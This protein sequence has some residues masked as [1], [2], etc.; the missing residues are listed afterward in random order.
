MFKIKLFYWLIKA[1]I[2]IL[3]I[4]SQDIFDFQK[5]LNLNKLMYFDTQIKIE[6]YSFRYLF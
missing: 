1:K 2:V 6:I 4:K 3:N 5:Y